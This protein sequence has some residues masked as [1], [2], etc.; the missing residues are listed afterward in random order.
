MGLGKTLT[1]ISLILK[2]RELEEERE[3][4]NGAK[5]KDEKELWLSKKS[6]V[7]ILNL[8]QGCHIMDLIS[9]LYVYCLGI[10]TVEGDPGHLPGEPPIAVG[11][12]GQAEGQ[13]GRH[14]SPRIP[15]HLQGAICQGGKFGNTRKAKF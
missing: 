11:G 7:D 5:E 12:R 15:R 14:A 1:M 4:Q 8:Y 10:R 3:T 2:H 9:S 6:K 13:V